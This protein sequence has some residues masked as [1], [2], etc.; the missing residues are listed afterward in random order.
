MSVEAGIWASRLGLSLERGGMYGEGGEE[1]E[2]GEIS[3]MCESIGHR[4]LQGRCPKTS[5]SLIISWIFISISR[6]KGPDFEAKVTK[7][8]EI[9]ILT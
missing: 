1:G 5:S 3:P 6:P 7:M 9:A 2:E 4:P 8:T